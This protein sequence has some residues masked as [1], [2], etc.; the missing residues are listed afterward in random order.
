M[1]IQTIPA[2]KSIFKRWWFWVA[3]V[4]LL[5][6]IGSQMSGS[7][8]PTAIPSTSEEQTTAAPAPTTPPTALETSTPAT[9]APTTTK[10]TVEA[11]PAEYKSALTK[12]RSYADIM[13]M[14]KTGVYDQLVSEYG[15]KFSPEAAQYAIDS[16]EHD[17]NANALAKAKVYQ[18]EMAMS[19]AA[20][21]DQLI[22]EYGEQFTPEEA[23]YAIDNLNN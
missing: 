12:A 16:L 22:S 23:Q 7:D 14:S 21:Y 4:V 3:I 11:V 17:W 20:I 2:K 15:E 6:G 19:P 1:S 5:A 10:P 8:T 18:D 13:K 9:P